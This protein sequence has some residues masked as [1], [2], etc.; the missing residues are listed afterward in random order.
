MVRCWGQVST[1]RLQS[2]GAQFQNARSAKKQGVL[3]GNLEMGV[4]KECGPES[5]SGIKPR[6]CGCWWP[7]CGGGISKPCGEAS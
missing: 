4:G 3:G 2:L 5:K 1:K 6:V 7:I